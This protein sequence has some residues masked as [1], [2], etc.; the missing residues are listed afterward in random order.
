MGPPPRNAGGRGGHPAGPKNTTRTPED[1][2][3]HRHARQDAHDLALAC[4]ELAPQVLAWAKL[5]AP[6]EREALVALAHRL[7]L[8]AEQGAA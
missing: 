7:G 8:A 5:A 1:S 3:T 2:S 6:G 4:A